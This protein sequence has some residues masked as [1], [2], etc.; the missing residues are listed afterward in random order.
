[1]GVESVF[2]THSN[3]YAKYSFTLDFQKLQ[4][5]HILIGFVIFLDLFEALKIVI[6]FQRLTKG[7]TKKFDKNMIK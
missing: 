5:I 2:Q 1:L 6:F 4:V 7:K 3:K